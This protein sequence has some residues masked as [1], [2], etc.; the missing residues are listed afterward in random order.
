MIRAVIIYASPFRISGI[1]MW[2]WS[3][4]RMIPPC[5]RH[6]EKDKTLYVPTTKHYALNS[7]TQNV[8]PATQNIHH[9]TACV[10]LNFSYTT[11]IC[12]PMRSTPSCNNQR[13]SLFYKYFCLPFLL[14]VNNTD[15][16]V[17]KYNTNKLAF[18]LIRKI[19]DAILNTAQLL[20]QEVAMKSTV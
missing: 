1:R 8:I 4:T 14:C 11:L 18:I 7:T 10:K 19:R 15:Y 17:L 20:V 3:T 5:A 16:H 13:H 2:T 12:C 6:L 9:N